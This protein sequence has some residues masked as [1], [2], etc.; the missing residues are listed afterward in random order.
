MACRK[1]PIKLGEIFLTFEEDLLIYAM[2]FKNMPLQTRLMEEGGNKYFAVSR[3]A[4]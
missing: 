4:V 2:Y 1:C 3:A